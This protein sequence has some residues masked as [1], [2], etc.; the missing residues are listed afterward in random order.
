MKI[1]DITQCIE[2]M[3]PLTLQ[4][5]YDNAGL[6]IGNR[7]N[8]A[9]AALLCLDITEDII[10]E[11]IAKGCNLI[12]SHHPLIFKGLKS[13]TGANYIERCILKACK[14][15]ISIYSAHT[16]IDNA[17]NGVNFKIAEK[18]GLT[19][20]KILVEQQ[21]M[22]LK[23]VTF[24]P[25]D[26]AEAVRNAIFES[27]AGNIGNYDACSYNLLG[28]G[29]FRA[30]K[31]ANPFC[32]EIDELH[33]EQETRIEVILPV[34]KKNAVIKALLSAH[35]YEEP[36][37]DFYSLNNAYARAGSG[38]IGELAVPISESDFLNHIKEI[39]SIP[40]IKHS[41]FI[42]KK[43]KK[44]ALCG[45]SGAFLLPEAIKQNADIFL[46]GEIK[47]HD[48]FGLDN[49]LLI[50][51]IGHY[52]SEQY[53]KEIFYDVITKKFPNFAIHFSDTNTNPVNYF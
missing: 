18:I 6:Q 9:S 28:Y 38:I 11:A 24:V 16:N 43:I 25:I 29:T 31:G 5:S 27:G 39:F 3:A 50:A 14:A 33:T 51:E 40:C 19:N 4:E 23:L 17:W 48:F 53:T 7:M 35:P 22:L 2:D 49:R 46:T 44:V 8:E 13:I 20:T 42:G 45:G 26:Q 1:Q 37:Y 32:G 15:D 41:S 21:N 47:Y 30:G 52:E 12:I 10:D 36:A 34:F